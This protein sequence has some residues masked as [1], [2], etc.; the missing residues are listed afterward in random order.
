[1]N[2]SISTRSWVWTDSFS[3]APGW[4]MVLLGIL[5]VIAVLMWMFLPFAIYGAKAILRQQNARL[6]EIEHLLRD[7]LRESKA[8]REVETPPKTPN[9][10]D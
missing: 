7:V 4:L 5:C 1:V 2:E 9:A 3:W 10:R 6:S 8:S